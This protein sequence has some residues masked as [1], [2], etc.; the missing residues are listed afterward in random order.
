MRTGGRSPNPRIR[1]S[2]LPTSTDIAWAD[3]FTDYDSEPWNEA[4]GL[5]GS[6]SSFRNALEGW[7]VADGQGIRF[8]NG[9]HNRVHVWVGGSMG[10]GTSPNDP[11]FFLHHAYVDKLHLG[12]LGDKKSK[13]LSSHYWRS[14]RP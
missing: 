2:T 13:R 8:G 5:Q 3:A 14:T 9:L 12:R 7:V 10:P 11:I 1:R 6:G 4:S